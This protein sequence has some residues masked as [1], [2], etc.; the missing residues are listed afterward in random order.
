MGE[1]LFCGHSLDLHGHDGCLVRCFDEI[2]QADGP[3]E[4][5]YPGA[6][7]PLWEDE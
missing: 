6:Q 1:C 3:C 7:E 4:C 5:F 2:A